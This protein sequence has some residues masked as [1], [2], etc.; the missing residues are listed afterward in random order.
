MQGKEKHPVASVKSTKEKE[1]QKK[2]AKNVAALKAAK[3]IF[4]YST[5]ISSSDS[6]LSDDDQLQPNLY[7]LQRDLQKKNQKIEELQAKLKQKTKGKVLTYIVS[8][9]NC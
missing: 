3:E 6:S 4:S 9:V 2:Q 1:R 8:M 5:M 7:Q